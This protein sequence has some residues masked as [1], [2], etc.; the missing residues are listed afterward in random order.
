MRANSKLAGVRAFFEEPDRYLHRDFQVQ[1]RAEIVRK[2]LSHADGLDIL[3][4]GC[5]D[6]RVS[7]QF[8]PEAEHITLVDLSESM[9]LLARHHVPA[10]C[11][12]KVTVLE[13][14]FMHYEPSA[15]SDVVICLGVLAH[16]EQVDSTVRKL[17]SLTRVGGRCVVQI[18]DYDRPMGKVQYLSSQPLLGRASEHGYP[19]QPTRFREIERLAAAHGMRLG[20]RSNHCLMLPGMG[21]LPNGWLLRYDRF[22]LKNWFL[23]RLAPSS[24]LMFH[25]GEAP[26]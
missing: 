23:R 14:D 22:V 10:Q 15:P 24:V 7:L 8:L 11:E 18:T 19:L 2:M 6:G 21:R 12:D 20:Q 13:G 4:I 3:D 25:R 16:V 1:T 17:A 5:G 9:L 26:V